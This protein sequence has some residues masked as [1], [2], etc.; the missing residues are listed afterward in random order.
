ILESAARAWRLSG[1]SQRAAGL[2][3]AALEAGRSG[4]TAAI[5]ASAAHPTLTAKAAADSAP[6][7]GSGS[8]AARRGPADRCATTA[9]A[10]AVQSAGNVRSQ[11]VFD[12]ND[13]RNVLGGD[14]H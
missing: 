11:S 13:L 2:I 6:T 12:R 7:G 10:Q 4:V 1:G 9:P 8:G 14:R 5:S 3:N